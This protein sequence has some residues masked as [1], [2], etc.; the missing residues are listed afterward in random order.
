M[1][2][3]SLWSAI[4]AATALA[5]VA[6]PVAATADDGDGRDDVRRAGWCTGDGEVTLR[7]RADDETIRVELEIE[8]GRR[9]ARWTVILLHERRIVFRAALRSRNDG[10]LRVRRELPD[11]PGSDNVTARASEPLGE[12]CRVSATV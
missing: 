5:L 9:G 6:L 12:S 1:G 10:S 4:L 8:R 2:K 3:R 11:W 7:L